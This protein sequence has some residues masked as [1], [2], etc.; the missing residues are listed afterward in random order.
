MGKDNV[1]GKNWALTD[2]AFLHLLSWLDQDKQLAGEKFER[3]RQKLNIFFEHRG[4]QSPDEL[5]D[6]T[7]DRVARKLESGQEINIP[8]PASYCYGVAHNVLKEFWRSPSRDIISLDSQPSGSNPYNPAT[9]NTADSDQTKETEINLN[10]LDLC[11]KKL[12]LEDRMLILKYYEGDH[13][14]RINNR[15]E[16]SLQ[17]GIPPGS[18]RIRALRIR[19]Q[20]YHCINRCNRHGNGK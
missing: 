16:L 15:H 11:L 20:L 7:L 2:V 18:L 13:R 6:Q 8:D 3:L 1:S 19:E 5:T 12:S 14:Q 9:V 17:L 4:C 10:H